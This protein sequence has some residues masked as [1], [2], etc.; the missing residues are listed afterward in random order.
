MVEAM[1]AAAIIMV[2]TGAVAG[3]AYTSFGGRAAT[4][5]AYAE[6]FFDISNMAYLNSSIMSCLSHPGSRCSGILKAVANVYG[7]R[8]I[9]VTDNGDSASYGNWIG[10]G[11]I[12][13]ECLPVRSG[14][15][16]GISCISECGG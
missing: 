10:C 3:M 7:L 6:S 2:A 4:S 12:R 16:Y 14:P 15:G 8:Y 5:P 13:R 1:A 11:G 9:R